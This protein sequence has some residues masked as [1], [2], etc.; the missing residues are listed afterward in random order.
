MARSKVIIAESGGSKTDWVVLEGD[1][2]IDRFTTKSYHPAQWNESIEQNE[3]AF[4]LKKA[5]ILNITLYFFGAGCYRDEPKSNMR[6]ILSRLGFKVIH[7][8][9]DLHAAG[10]ALFGREE[11]WGAILGTGSVLFHWKNKDVCE[12]VGGKGAMEGDEGSGFYFGKLLLQSNLIKVRD[13][14]ELAE[15]QQGDVVQNRY[16]IAALSLK[17]GSSKLL[18]PIHEQNLTLFIERYV[19]PIQIDHVSVVGG[20]ASSIRSELVDL[21]DKEG[22][23]VDQIIDRPIQL[24]VEQKDLFIE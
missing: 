18:R 22:I 8:F 7:V 11:G 14:Q 24:L 23:K 6:T 15:L 3:I 5:S 1:K 4:W 20:Y 17:Y 16:A 12:V 2:I 19:C 13:V 21:F 9:S 10:Y